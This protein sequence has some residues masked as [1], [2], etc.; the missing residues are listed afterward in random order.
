MVD[1]EYLAG[2]VIALEA[3]D[4]LTAA[5][6][7]FLTTWGTFQHLTDGCSQSLRIV[8]SDIETVWPTSLL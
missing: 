5:L 8:R 2:D 4:V 7:T 3:T 1:L 6:D